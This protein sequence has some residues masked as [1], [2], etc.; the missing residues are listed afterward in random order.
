VENFL[1]VV[2]EFLMK[3][4]ISMLLPS[5]YFPDLMLAAFIIS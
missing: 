1:G 2:T 4:G 3:Q 5:T